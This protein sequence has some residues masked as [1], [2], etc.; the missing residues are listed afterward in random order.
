DA[1]YDEMRQ[2]AR[3]AVDKIIAALRNTGTPS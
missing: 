1:T 3:D 2:K